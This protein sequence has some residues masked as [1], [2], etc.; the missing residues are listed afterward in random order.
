MSRMNSSGKTFARNS[1]GRGA[2][3]DFDAAFAIEKARHI[4]LF[5]KYRY[6][7]VC[8]Y[9]AGDLVAYIKSDIGHSFI[10]PKVTRFPVDDVSNPDG[11]IV[12]YSVGLS[13]SDP[14]RS[15]DLRVV[16]WI[17]DDNVAES[18][19][20]YI[21]SRQEWLTVIS[22]PDLIEVLRSNWYL[23]TNPSRQSEAFLMS[24][25][26]LVFEA[27]K[28]IDTCES[29]DTFCELWAACACSPALGR[30]V[31]RETFLRDRFKRLERN[32]TTWS[33]EL[34]ASCPLEI[35]DPFKKL[36]SNYS[37]HV[38]WDGIFQN[39]IAN[40]RDWL[41]NTKVFLSNKTWNLS[42]KDQQDHIRQL[43]D[44]FSRKDAK[45]FVGYGIAN[46]LAF[47]DEI[48]DPVQ[49]HVFGR[50]FESIF[51]SSVPIHDWSRRWERCLQY[52][53][54][55]VSGFDEASRERW[56][57]A[58]LGKM[59][60][61]P[62]EDVFRHDL[63]ET[64]R[65]LTNLPVDKL[66][67][68]KN[69]IDTLFVENSLAIDLESNGR[70]VFQIGA[71]GNKRNPFFRDLTNLSAVREPEVI[72]QLASELSG[73]WLVGHNVIEWDLPILFNQAEDKD[74]QALDPQTRPVWDT[75]LAS[76]VLTPWK[77]T[78]ALLSA[79]HRADVD[80][81]AAF[82]LFKKQVDTLGL[83]FSELLFGRAPYTLAK[84]FAILETVKTR[85]LPKAPEFLKAFP[86]HTHVVIPKAWLSQVAWLPEVGYAF[87]RGHIDE[88][89]WMIVAADVKRWQVDNGN[90][91]TPHLALLTLLT[92]SERENIRVRVG[93]LPQWLRRKC[94]NCIRSVSKMDNE[95]PTSCRWIV[96]TYESYYETGIEPPE[97]GGSINWV[98]P[99][100]ASLLKAKNSAH[101][102][103][104]PEALQVGRKH[105]EA[106]R[107]NGRDHRLLD[108]GQ[109]KTGETVWLEWHPGRAQW[110]TWRSKACCDAFA[111]QKTDANLSFIRPSWLEVE[112]YGEVVGIDSLW[113]TTSSRYPYWRDTLQKVIS[114][115]ARK[116]KKGHLLVFVVAGTKE[117]S[118]IEDILVALEKAWPAST[119][120]AEILRKAGGES[121]CVVVEHEQVPEWLQ[122]ATEE[123]YV[124]FE[125]VVEALPVE[126]WL[127]C[128]RSEEQERGTGV[129]DEDRASANDEEK[130]ASDEEVSD[131]DAIGLDS[132]DDDGTLTHGCGRYQVAEVDIERAITAY[133]DI[134]LLS[135]FCNHV[136][137]ILDSRLNIV[138]T[139]QLSRV[140]KQ[141][142]VELLPLSPEVE[143]VFDERKAML[144][145]RT[146]SARLPEI[147][148]LFQEY[149]RFLGQ[150][151]KRSDNSPAEFRE[152]QKPAVQAI[153]EG[154][155]VL[156]RLPTGEGK[157]V[158]FQV[159]A[160]VNASHTGKLTVVVT[161]LRAL[162]K[163]QVENLRKKSLGLI[164]VDY[165]SGDR[166][167]WETAEV[168]QHIL[169]GSIELLFVAPE[170]FRVSRFRDVL[171]RRHALDNGL[172]FAV[173][174]EAHCISQWGYEF[175]P[176]YLY[177]ISEIRKSFLQPGTST[178]LLLLSAT[179]TKNTQRILAEVTGLSGEGTS[180]LVNCPDGYSFPIKD[181]LQIEPEAVA[182]GLY[183]KEWKSN[184]EFRVP[185][186]TEVIRQSNPEI[187]TVLIFVTRRDHAEHLRDRLREE[188]DLSEF[189]IEAF[190][191][192]MPS[193]ER[194]RILESLDP[195]KNAPAARTN[196]LISTKAFGMGMDIP[197][198]HWA[199]HLA[200][201]SFLEDYLQEIGRCGRDEV[202]LKSIGHVKLICN[203]LWNSGDFERN[204]ENVKRGLIEADA[205]RK[206]WDEITRRKVVAVDGSKLCVLPTDAPEL[207]NDVPPDKLGR[208]LS[209]LENEPS[210]RIEIVGKLPDMLRM[211][212]RRGK[213]TEY[214]EGESDVA[215]VAAAILLVFRQVPDENKA[216]SERDGSG[217]GVSPMP[218][219]A[220]TS[221]PSAVVGGGLLGIIRRFVGFFIS[222]R[223][224]PQGGAAEADT[225]MA[226][227]ADPVTAPK[228][229]AADKEVSVELN[230]GEV[231]RRSGLSSPDAMW[232]ALCSLLQENAIAIE[233]TLIFKRMDQCDF[234]QPLVEGFQRAVEALCQ[235]RSEIACDKLP[236]LISELHI[237]PIAGQEVPD[238]R[239]MTRSVCWA[240]VKYLRRT[241]V[242]I[243]EVSDPR[244]ARVLRYSV[245]KRIGT[246]I[247]RQLDTCLRLTRDCS[248]LIRNASAAE[249]V[250][251]GKQ[252]NLDELVRLINDSGRLN[253]LR[254]AIGLLDDLKLWKT[255]QELIPQSYLLRLLTEDPLA[256]PQPETASHAE[257]GTAA[258]LYEG[259][260]ANDKKMF[261]RLSQINRF[262][263]LRSFA[264]EL[265]CLLPDDQARNAFIDAYFEEAT[266]PDALHQVME[267]FVREVGAAGSDYLRDMLGKI[268]GEAFT[269][270]FEGKDGKGGLS[271]EQKAI[272][273]AVFSQNMLVNAGPGAGKTHVLMMRAAHLI[274]VQRLQ[275]EQILILAFNRAVVHEIRTRIKDLFTKLGYGAYVRSL[276]VR[277]FHAFALEHMNET[278]DKAD[279][280]A[281]KLVVN[282][283]AERLQNDPAFAHS[284]VGGAR[285]ILVDE[286]QDMTDD[287]Y[288]VVKTLATTARET[289]GAGSMVIGDDDQDIMQW[290]RRKAG[291]P[292]ADGNE[293]FKTFVS[294]V[295]NAAT[296]NLTT[297]YRSLK[298]I[299]DSSQR[300][301]NA[302]RSEQLDIPRQKT[303][304][305]LKPY[306]SGVGEVKF[307]KNS[308][309]W[310]D[311][312]LLG[313]I[314]QAN[315]TNQSC[316]VLC[317]T[318]SQVVQSYEIIRKEYPE[319]VIQGEE[320]LRLNQLRHI[321]V[322]S[323]IIKARCKKDGNL[324]LSDKILEETLMLFK[325]ERIPEAT[326][327]D[328]IEEMRLIW[329][330]AQK[331]KRG[332]QLEDFLG[333]VDDIRT[334]DFSRIK[335]K[336]FE[337]D[338]KPHFSVVLSTIHKVKG[339]QFDRVWIQPS[340]AKFPYD[341]NVDVCDGMPKDE[342][343]RRLLPYAI[344]EAK[345][346]Y[347]AMTR[348]KDIAH[349]GWGDREKAWFSKLN[350]VETAQMGMSHLW[351]VGSLDEVVISFGAW[352]KDRLV[353]IESNVR[354]GY[355]VTINMDANHLL[356]VRHHEVEIATFSRD[357]G[358]VVRPKI[359]GPAG[360]DHT[361]YH[362]RVSAICRYAYDPGAPFAHR[363]VAEFKE[364]GWFYTVVL[365]GV[366]S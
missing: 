289:N 40:L 113:P 229:I 6:V 208:S 170:R 134:W 2:K 171:A 290:A 261:E 221:G 251:D 256:I 278:I 148:V 60:S 155:H 285:A 266:D 224:F 244:G 365:R 310:A 270:A 242:R 52:A 152:T 259:Q 231:F 7:G 157:S 160:L 64:G 293:Y 267:R 22:T 100:M 238:A 131:A 189:H 79:S 90:T 315:E 357:V 31:E 314:R 333:F 15:T 128:C 245:S 44:K 19:D 271:E 80:A 347:V 45:D 186:L 10:A 115:L 11:K 159:P 277:T 185:R 331:E 358:R 241:G 29:L 129:L 335:E 147:A 77:P 193:D 220:K 151:W 181:H 203:L 218:V 227:I 263:E 337:L 167:P 13:I 345:L 183:G 83:D 338:G 351:L 308:A 84:W 66:V 190:H 150:Y 327:E 286:F 112:R 342:R 222:D 211:R 239:R 26:L 141:E 53:V 34:P 355:P 47:L 27:E 96:S 204:H 322:F 124:S 274:H 281:L 325:S 233:R 215:V 191:A 161:P 71:V 209:W 182:I 55:A 114:L 248:Q 121:C 89:D 324:S 120:K 360:I 5:S 243:R 65:F 110:R 321:A 172:G 68:F 35:A 41:V 232:R 334:D 195:R 366:I 228:P 362:L 305:L 210:S 349:C 142:E 202:S 299:V 99:K 57:D 207:K 179:V 50:M 132:D 158:V 48:D 20:Q 16:R 328:A 237:R 363:V 291:D 127:T 200:P 354:V 166:D 58:E 187:S 43:L 177:A 73:K 49:K 174:D 87:P 162:M 24:D 136:P 316:A 247:A 74:K 102:V 72:A 273:Q 298:E 250:K 119:A 339:L 63:S 85:E 198:I 8:E 137:V 282:N 143:Q 17:T 258:S 356:V 223:S 125:F 336:Q 62:E 240:A 130:L 111:E 295:Q 303:N 149:E 230:M 219:A 82:T 184:I 153:A 194:Q 28:R 213:L 255:E 317:R 312:Q 69:Q 91:D 257:P 353:H 180:A 3:S 93:N 30:V 304:I 103:S 37:F 301:I 139:K 235:N 269:E 95:N 344:E 4:D 253:D 297:N 76:M 116:A 279:N 92:R 300:L 364:Q 165:L 135:E 123:S 12:Y 346:F 319:V 94:E 192:G 176:D 97:D 272:V 101:D 81:G 214:A 294:D 178:Q 265:F 105:G 164:T 98:A 246:V 296:L 9:V 21:Q 320:G 226:A 122:F 146:E 156:V 75:M 343:I 175:R 18:C 254:A 86:P 216:S 106:V 144:G 352:D 36:W 249:K 199:V 14:R 196:V 38:R 212:I 307:L 302:E 107:Q 275:P 359:M 252:I 108:C 262:S 201:P 268:R 138:R 225:T 288:A 348:A 42:D 313:F 217:D 46:Y 205:L 329:T 350:K 54:E 145:G 260:P 61:A 1:S 318:N 56:L 206:L 109:E 133:L 341:G 330:H 51:V 323:D 309:D 169:D 88:Q 280:N 168:Y 173:I 234:Q 117:R 292:I 78:H 284:V 23:E 104:V 25:D 154:R 126:F 340:D 140:G 276:R 67:M 70:Q 361:K 33:S 283:F 287:F 236:E 32:A 39:K 118:V 326:D 59:A 311:D 306:R 188:S 332:A 197:N 264:M 163:D